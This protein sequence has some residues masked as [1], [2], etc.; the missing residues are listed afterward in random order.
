MAPAA[1]VFDLGKVLLDFDY[2]V[3]ARRFAAQSTVPPEAIRLAMD[4][5]PLL[6]RF[7]TGQLS[8]EEFFS[9]VQRATGFKGDFAEF[10]GIFGDIFTPIPP[11]VELND[12][13][14]ARG[15]PTFIFSNTNGLAVSHVQRAFPFFQNFAG[16][17]Y[18]HE[19]RAMKPDSRIYE[20]VE[21]IAGHTGEALLYI[22]DRP[23]NIAAGRQRGW[24][25][26]LHQSPAATIHEVVATGLL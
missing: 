10:A 4:Q 22:D 18:S 6:H 9:E 17:V 5:S 12:R 11:M 8:N 14:R 16:Y 26:I 24:R 23:E 19:Q 1:V 25:A 7:E 20:V 3:A 15:V 2:G 21:R 13:L